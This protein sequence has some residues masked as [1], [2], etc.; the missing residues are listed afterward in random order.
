MFKMC[1]IFET[2]LWF[3]D[4]TLAYLLAK[5]QDSKLHID[6]A[7]PSVRLLRDQFAL[8]QVQV[9]F[10]ILVVDVSSFLVLS[11]V[12]FSSDCCSPSVLVCNKIR[13]LD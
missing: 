11:V 1:Q 7:I 6:P 8:V 2:S 5:I 9:L 13:I 4:V 3:S 12:V 10:C